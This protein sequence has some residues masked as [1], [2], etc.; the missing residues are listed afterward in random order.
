MSKAPEVKNEPIE[1][2]SVEL[3]TP[4]KLELKQEMKASG[5]G[6]GKSRNILSNSRSSAGF[7]VASGGATP[8]NVPIKITNSNSSIAASTVAKV[9]PVAPPKL[10]QRSSKVISTPPQ[11]QKSKLEK[12]P[13]KL[14]R[15]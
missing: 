14:L 13:Q 6:A 7:G 10:S 4:Q 8:E 9:A 15:N 2:A 11:N 12:V 5:S 3:P 1:I